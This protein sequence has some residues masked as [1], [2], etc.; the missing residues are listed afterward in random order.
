MIKSFKDKH[1]QRLF[2]DQ[3][4]RRFQFTERRA[5]LKLISLDAATQLKDLMVPPSN[6]LERL[7]GDRHGQYSIRINNRWR[8]CFRW[9]DGNAEDAEIVD[10]H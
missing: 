2:H 10:Y 8:M 9:R 3:Y 1:T 5:R 4:V 7:K 6:Q